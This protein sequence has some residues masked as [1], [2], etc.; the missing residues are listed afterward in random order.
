[1]F[2]L[3]R[4]DPKGR[5]LTK[6]GNRAHVTKKAAQVLKMLLEHAGETVFK[7]ILIEKVWGESE[8]KGNYLEQKICELRKVFDDNPKN[9][10]FIETVHG[11]GYK[12][13]APVKR[14]AP[15]ERVDGDV[16]TPAL[17]AKTEEV[18]APVAKNVDA[19]APAA[20]ND[21]I[22]DVKVTAAMEQG[23]HNSKSRE[24]NFMLLMTAAM[25]SMLALALLSISPK[26]FI[27]RL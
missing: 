4:L 7:E 24:S 27:S 20:K 1:M 13:I 18:Q 26:T 10:R 16:L 22:K 5:I 25:D 8:D 12:F 9:P 17:T 19:Q 2:G 15:I 21:E 3:F 23:Q 6:G 11:E 14:V